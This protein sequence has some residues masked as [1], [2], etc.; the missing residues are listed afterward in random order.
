MLAHGQTASKGQ[1]INLAC[2]ELRQ[3][4]LRADFVE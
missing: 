2:V 1:N 4:L 3:N